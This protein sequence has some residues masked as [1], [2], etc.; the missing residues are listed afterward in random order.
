MNR[1][2]AR[3]GAFAFVCFRTVFAL[4]GPLFAMLS[5]VTFQSLKCDEFLGTMVA[6]DH[7][8]NVDSLVDLEFP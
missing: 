8:T 4:I 5:E 7:W 2:V 6:G 1:L 3:E